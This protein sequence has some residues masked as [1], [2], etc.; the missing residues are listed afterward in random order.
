MRL[1]LHGLD[2]TNVRRGWPVPG[3]HGAGKD[4]GLLWMPPRRLQKQFCHSG[5]AVRRVS[6]HVTQVAGK[7]GV[8]CDAEIVVRIDASVERTRHPRP[9][10]LL[11]LS[12]NLATGKRQHKVEARDLIASEVV[13][14]AFFQF[15]AAQSDWCIQVV[16]DSKRP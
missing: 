14:A 13:D 9:K 1:R 2:V 16:E 6:G 4:E 12:Q 8:G 5:L 15:D 3:I 10:L 7:R 11:Q